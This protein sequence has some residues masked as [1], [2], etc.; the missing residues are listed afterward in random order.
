[1]MNLLFKSYDEWFNFLKKSNVQAYYLHNINKHSTLFI[2]NSPKYVTKIF[3]RQ[4][5][6]ANGDII[7]SIVSLSKITTDD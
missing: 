5:L 3:L 2:Y 7:N 4:F 6:N 1:M